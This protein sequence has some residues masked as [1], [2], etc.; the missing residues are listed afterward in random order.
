MISAGLTNLIEK[1][2]ILMSKS[3]RALRNPRVRSVFFV[4]FIYATIFL[5]DSKNMHKFGKSQL[6]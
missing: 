5:Q 3:I 6:N 1:Y 2:M 4:G